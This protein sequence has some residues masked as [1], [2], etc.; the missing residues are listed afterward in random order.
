MP[1]DISEPARGALAVGI[2][3]A[4]A[5]RPRNRNDATRLTALHVAANPQ[6]G[7]PVVEQE[8]ERV[9]QVFGDA[10]GVD[11]DTRTES[12]AP[13]SVIREQAERGAYDMIVMATRG[14]TPQK[15]ALG[16][17]SLDVVMKS[18]CPVLLVPPGVWR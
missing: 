11:I 5:L 9:R 17:V 16:S 12:G 3:W 6:E 8:V 2:T 13:A 7:A 4:S 10:I 14:E 15:A 18:A 1:L